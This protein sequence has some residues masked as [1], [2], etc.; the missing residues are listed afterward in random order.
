MSL[1]ALRDLRLGFKASKCS[2]RRLKVNI[3]SEKLSEDIIESAKKHFPEDITD[4]KIQRSRRI[5]LNVNKENLIEVAQF[6]KDQHGFDHIASVSGIDYPDRKEFEIVYHVWSIPNKIMLTL[7]TS[8]SRDEPKVKT[9]TPVWEGANYHER[10]AHE[11]FGIDF[12]GHPNLSELLL[13]GWDKEPPF[14][15]DFKL[16]T[17][18]EE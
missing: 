6:L 14:R 15:K 4:A 1:D 11:L 8:T 10:E 3:V 18:L 13:E 9:L 2:R 17:K 7:R 12:D 5:V 16:R